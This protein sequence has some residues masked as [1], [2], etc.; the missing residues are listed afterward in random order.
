[1][2]QK[3]GFIMSNIGN[4][5]PILAGLIAVAIIIGIVFITGV[6]EHKNNDHSPSIYTENVSYNNGQDSVAPNISSFNPS[7]IFVQVVKRVQ[8]AIV[9]V[10]TKKKIKVQSNPF[11]KFFWDFGFEKED[12]G[13]E[14][15][16]EQ[17]GLGSGIIVSAEGYILTNNHVVKDMDELSVRL[18]DDEEYEAKIIGTDPTTDIALIKIEAK[19]LNVAVLGNSD[20]LEIGEWVLAIGSPLNLKSTVTA[21]IVSALGRDIGIIRRRDGYSIENFI[22]T[23]A[24]I[25]PGNSGGALVNYKGEVIGVNT[26]IAS[27]TGAYIGYGFAIPINMAKSVMDDFINYGEIRRGYLGIYI[28]EVTPT[29]AEG[30]GLDKPQGVYVRGVMENSAA[31]KAGVKIGDIILEIEGVE[32]SKPNQVQAKVS[33]YDPGYQINLLIW[34]DGKKTT[35][36]VRLGTREGQTVAESGKKGTMES[37]IKSLGIKVKDLSKDELKE[38]DISH[39]VYVQ[40]IDNNSPA[41]SS[42]LRPGDV[43]F[44]LDGVKISSVEQ[45]NR[46]VEKKKEGDILKIKV[47]SKDPSGKSFTQLIFIKIK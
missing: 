44:N 9:T 31:E 30:V 34:R 3:G 24:A 43:I 12:E 29:I 23:D 11:F 5:F 35:F 26:A 4:K 17:T 37:K 47:F 14:Q 1:M 32:M 46:E 25:N 45:F 38:L 16:L 27:Q 41:V 7:K 40:S 22:Q 20:D 33:S 15:E 13:D 10:Y 39:G 19:D 42:G 36:K 2:I 21:G 18:V 6:D 8:P 28:A